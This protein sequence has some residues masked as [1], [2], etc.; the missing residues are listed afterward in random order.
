MHIAVCT[1]T[2]N[3]GWAWEWSRLSFDNQDY[4]AE[5]LTWIVVDNSDEPGNDWSA[6]K[7][8][9]RVK[10][11]HVPGKVHLGEMRNICLREALKTDADYIAFW[12]D[13]DYY[14]PQRLSVAVR[15]LAASPDCAYA[16][17]RKMLVLLIDKNVL[18]SVG[19][20]NENHSTAA[21]WV[22]RR[23]Y[24]EANT[25][26]STADKAEEGAFMRGWTTKM[27]SI[28]PEDTILV[29]GH[30]ANTVD[31]GQVRARAQIFMST[32]VNSANGKMVARMKWFRTPEVWARFLSTFFDASGKKPRGST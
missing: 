31:K 21:T 19:P 14:V 26:E 29:M 25:F 18:I 3:R 20:Y 23:A 10:Y 27:V 9:P 2:R 17:C 24:A 11:M 22:M 32:D 1:P 5:K 13:D 12:D 7:E 30:S 28:E 8:H 16:G 4:P 15:A 6:S